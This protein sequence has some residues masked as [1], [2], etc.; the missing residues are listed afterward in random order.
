MQPLPSLTVV[1]PNFNHGHLIGDQLRS[2]LAQSVQP[3]KIIIIDDA[4]TDD[5]VSIIRSIISLHQNVELV[6]KETNSGPLRVMNEA[7]R[8][9]KT[10]LV[11]FLAADDITLPGFFEKSLTLFSNYPEAA[12]CSGI[13]LVKY[14]SERYAVPSW[15]AYPC[16]RPEFLTPARVRKL[17]LRFGDWFMGNT[18]VYRRE[19]LL[20]EGGFDL[21]LRSFAD[22][23]LSW[24]LA[25]RHGACFI[26]EPLAVF[27]RLDSGYSSSTSRDESTYAQL[28]TVANSRMATKFKDLFP[29]EL[30]E[31]CSAR[32]LS[33]VL[34][35]KLNNFEAHVQKMVGAAQPIG[36]GALLLFAIH[37]ANRILIALFFCVLRP[38][39]IPRFALSTLWRRS[40]RVRKTTQQAR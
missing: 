13:S 30:V 14:H 16:S 21:E 18:T 35:V 17:L 1:I 34:W 9:V 26:P 3:A 19:L 10:E 38:Y 37:W 12:I 28:L 4:S 5:S 27:R 6:C 29:A 15:L 11:T 31:R 23:F 2:I 20:A 7:L 24:V 36:G 8:F 40:P 32:M 33:R 25:L 22:G 39:D